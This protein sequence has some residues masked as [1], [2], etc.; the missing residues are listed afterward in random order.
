MERDTIKAIMY[1]GINELMNNKDYY[2]RSAINSRYS[3]W[4]EKGMKELIE[5]SLLMS[6][7]IQEAEDKELNK[8]AKDLVIKG[9]KG[10]T[11]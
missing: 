7:H 8:R 3:E 10:E 1:G 5:Y 11:V 6:Q 9:L 2:R 4:T